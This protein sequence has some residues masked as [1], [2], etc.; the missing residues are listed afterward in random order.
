MYSLL[1]FFE[2]GG[3]GFWILAAIVSVVFTVAVE[4]RKFWFSVCVAVGMALLYSKPLIA[5]THNWKASLLIGG[6]YLLA[7]V[8]WSIGRWHGY[9]AKLINNFKE[10]KLECYGINSVSFLSLET[11]LKI[12]ENKSLLTG[13]IAY[14]PWDAGW[15][16]TGNL[17]NNLFEL[18]RG[19]YQKIADQQLSSFKESMKPKDITVGKNKTYN[20]VN[21]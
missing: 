9:V 11:D 14:W 16:L 2:L 5:F 3:L 18:V 13:W 1:A 8:C 21:D 4:T 17:F 6:A 15:Q 10:N 12:T 19:V 20:M 7:G